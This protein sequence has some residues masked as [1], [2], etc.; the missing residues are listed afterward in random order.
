MDSTKAYAEAKKLQKP[1][2]YKRFTLYEFT[3]EEMLRYIGVLM[4]LSVNSVRSYRQAWNPR[5]S[6][7][8]E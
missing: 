2:M 7:V 4:L 1:A 5:S 6:Q 8:N 3:K